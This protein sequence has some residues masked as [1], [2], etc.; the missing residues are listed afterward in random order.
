M[1]LKA[2]RNTPQFTMK[3][4]NIQSHTHTHIRTHSYEGVHISFRLSNFLCAAA[5][6]SLMCC[7]LVYVK[8]VANVY[9]LCY[10]VTVHNI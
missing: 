10:L 9:F 8:S 6:P 1:H 5:S 3:I 7:Y 4:K 2:R